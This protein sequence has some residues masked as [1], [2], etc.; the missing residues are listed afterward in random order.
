MPVLRAERDVDSSYKV[1]VRAKERARLDKNVFYGKLDS[2]S[3]ESITLISYV[4]NSLSC[5]GE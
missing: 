5:H 2:F 3:C 4:S 1:T